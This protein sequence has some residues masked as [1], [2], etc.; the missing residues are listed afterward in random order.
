M[1]QPCQRHFLLVSPGKLLHGNVHGCRAHPHHIR[2]FLRPS[3]LL[4]EIDPSTMRAGT[5][6]RERNVICHRHGQR[7]AFA[8]AVFAQIAHAARDARRRRAV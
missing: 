5:Q 4:R 6:A 2:P 1:Q 3:L 7:Q 8:F